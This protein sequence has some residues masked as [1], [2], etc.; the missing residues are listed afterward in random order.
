MINPHIDDLKEAI[1]NA[2]T[3]QTQ[4][5]IESC[6]GVI[7][8]SG[9]SVRRRAGE[10]VGNLQRVGRPGVCENYSHAIALVIIAKTLLNNSFGIDT[11][12]A[13]ALLSV[14]VEKTNDYYAVQPERKRFKK[15]A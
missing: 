1:D 11:V 9:V 12:A 8:S 14:A 4:A 2:R 5:A 13:I 7:D 3:G 15:L 6:Q 10:V